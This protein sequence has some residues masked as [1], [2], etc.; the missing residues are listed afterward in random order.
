MDLKFTYSN[1]IYLDTNILSY[2]AKHHLKWSFLQKFLIGND[3]CIAVSDELFA[4]LHD[5]KK[6]HNQ[7]SSLLLFIPSAIIK[8]GD[9]IIEE[10]VKSHPN[11]R[12]ETLL[13]CPLNH[14][15]KDKLMSL[16]SSKKLEMAREKQLQQAK[17]MLEVHK[18]LKPNF[19]PSNSGKYIKSQDSEFVDNITFQLLLATHIEFLEDFECKF[20]KLNLKIF[21]SLKTY[22]Y[23][24]FYKYYL[25]NREPDKLSDFGDLFH[26]FYIPYCKIAIMERDLC[27]V[28]NQIKQNSDILNDVEIRNINFFKKYNNILL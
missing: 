28:L 5:A 20:E 19:P 26:V 14:L 10:E 4:E 12:T 18:K 11:Q 21:L 2:L 13:F 8:T 3:L 17:K 9:K 27:N 24:I 16:F 15:K 25:Q 7:L 22:A 6:L 1:F 23:T